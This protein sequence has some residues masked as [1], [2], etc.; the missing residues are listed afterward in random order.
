MIESVARSPTATARGGRTGQ[1]RRAA[2]RSTSHSRSVDSLF[3]YSPLWRKSNKHLHLPVIRRRSPGEAWPAQEEPR[4][5]QPAERRVRRGRRRRHEQPG[6]LAG[7]VP[8]RAR[9]ARRQGHVQAPRREGRPGARGHLGGADGAEEGGGAADGGMAQ[10][11][12]KDIS[13]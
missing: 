7:R 11:D 13:G 4:R 5:H 1:A 10:G 3:Q 6:L 8:V 9:A 2:A 12:L